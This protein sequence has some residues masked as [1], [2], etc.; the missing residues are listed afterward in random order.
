MVVDWPSQSLRMATLI[1]TPGTASISTETSRRTDPLP[2]PGGRHPDRG[3]RRRVP[4]APAARIGLGVPGGLPRPRGGPGRVGEHGRGDLAGRRDRRRPAGR[5]VRGPGGG[6]SATADE[7]ALRGLC[8]NFVAVAGLLAQTART[9]RQTEFTA[10]RQ[11]A[12]IPLDE[13]GAVV[14]TADRFASDDEWVAATSG[15]PPEV[16]RALLLRFGLFGVRLSIALLHQGIDSPAALAAELVR[17]LRADRAAARAA[18]PVRRAP[19]P[20]QGPLGAARGGRRAAGRPA[21]GQRRAGARGRADL[22]RGAR[23]RRAAA[24]GRVALAARCRCP[25]PVLAEAE[26]LLGETGAAVRTRL[27]L[28]PATPARTQVHA[29]ALAALNRWQDLAENPM[30]PGP[31]PTRA[32]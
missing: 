3:R 22:L 29:A 5:D 1:D 4:D 10:L 21:A 11:L 30:T 15:L 2:Q 17:A 8:Q 23:V 32:G 6:A 26:R 18:Q 7:P 9:L 13:L 20:A 12:R 14:F 16:R 24:A 25:A 31:R 19:R 27:A 28:P